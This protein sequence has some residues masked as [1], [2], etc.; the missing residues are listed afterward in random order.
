MWAMT[1]SSSFFNLQKIL[2]GWK[3]LVPKFDKNG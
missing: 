3:N 2:Y 1:L